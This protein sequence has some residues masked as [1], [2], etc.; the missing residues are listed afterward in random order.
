MC[1]ELKTAPWVVASESLILVSSE[2]DTHSLLTSSAAVRIIKTISLGFLVCRSSLCRGENL[3]AEKVLLRSALHCGKHLV[4]L[5][6]IPNI[7]LPEC[8]CLLA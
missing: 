5:D 2:I 8:V 3:A 4:E 7:N 1:N 6:S